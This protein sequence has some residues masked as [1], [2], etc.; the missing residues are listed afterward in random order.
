ML[1]VCADRHASVDESFTISYLMLESPGLYES[2]TIS[3]PMLE[4]PG[5]HTTFPSSVV[6]SASLTRSYDTV[7]CGVARNL[8]NER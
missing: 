6:K 7:L 5:L 3:Y 1:V 2:C 8:V 4:S